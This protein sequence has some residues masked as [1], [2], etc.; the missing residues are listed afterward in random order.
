MP[1]P[2]DVTPSATG[3]TAWHRCEYYRTECGLP[4]QLVEDDRIVLQLGGVFGAVTMPV[5]LGRKV[6][7]SLQGRAMPA[8]ALAH[9]GGQ[10]WTLLSGPGTVTLE[11]VAA[12]VPLGVSVVG[13]TAVV[14]LPSPE[15]EALDLWHWVQQPSQAD[16]PP[17]AA[18]LAT[19]RAMAGPTSRTRSAQP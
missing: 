13:E 5:G 17:Q 3:N 9:P 16:L 2:C 14:V 1:V 11:E 8:P 19:T 15:T 7:A 4:A 18:L 10:R 6:I 12:L